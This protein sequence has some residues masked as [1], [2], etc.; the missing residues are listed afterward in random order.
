MSAQCPARRLRGVSLI[1]L[2]VVLIL[3]GAIVAFVLPRYLGGV[4]KD[5]VTHRTPVTQARDA[6]C[7]SNLNQ[8]RASIQAAS[9]GDPDGRPPSSLGELGMPAEVTVCP[10]GGEAYIYDAAAGRIQCPHPGHEGY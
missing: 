5:A 3:F 9:V 6:V 10:T 7:R 8:L 4:S 1:E 2:F